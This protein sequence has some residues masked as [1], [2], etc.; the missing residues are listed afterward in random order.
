MH[1]K[2]NY[3]LI[4]LFLIIIILSATFFKI[5]TNGYSAVFVDILYFYYLIVFFVLIISIIVAFIFIIKFYN[6]KIIK[7][8]KYVYY[9]NQLYDEKYESN[10]PY[11]S[12]ECLEESVI[13]LEKNTF[14]TVEALIESLRMISRSHKHL[15]SI[16]NNDLMSYLKE[17]S[18]IH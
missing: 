6:E 10:R 14:R 7:I 16:V 12:I 8:N 9:L 1:H 13:D 18:I 2:K 11:E 17:K 4:V 3:I 15:S 5:Y